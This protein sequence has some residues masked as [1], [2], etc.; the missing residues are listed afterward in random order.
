[1]T[2]VARSDEFSVTVLP[3]GRAAF[4]QPHGELD[5]GTAPVLEQA[6]RHVEGYDGLVLDLRGL[7]F[8]DS[9]GVHL[10]VGTCERADARGCE[11]RIVTGPPEVQRV[12]EIT[13]LQERLL[14]YL[15]HPDTEA[16]VLASTG[17]RPS[18]AGTG[19]ST[20]TSAA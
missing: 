13:G 17:R 6:L 15:H 10:V 9:S 14:P 16:Q 18:W 1:M 7:A 20:N 2:T 11:L 4:V 5:L 12:F 3:D 8:S 19:S